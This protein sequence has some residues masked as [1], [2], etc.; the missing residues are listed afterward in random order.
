MVCLLL[1]INIG[2]FIQKV[3]KFSNLNLMTVLSIRVH[4]SCSLVQ[5][6]NEF[7]CCQCLYRIVYWHCSIYI[8]KHSYKN[9]LAFLQLQ[10]RFVHPVEQEHEMIS[11]Q[12]FRIGPCVVFRSGCSLLSASSSTLKFQVLEDE[13]L[14]S[15]LFSLQL[16]DSGN[17]LHVV[18][19]HHLSVAVPL[20]FL[21]LKTK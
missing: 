4:T 20:A 14:S 13:A 6:I 9:N 21:S 19:K 11:W 18:I 16:P 2:K 10:R 15:D 3:Y 8:H 5:Y 12:A 7:I 17:A 1:P